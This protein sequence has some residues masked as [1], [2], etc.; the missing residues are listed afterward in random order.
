MNY[1]AK[2]SD[3]SLTRASNVLLRNLRLNRKT[4]N[5]LKRAGWIKRNETGDQTDAREGRVN[6]AQRNGKRNGTGENAGRKR[7][8]QQTGRKRGTSDARGNRKRDGRNGN[9]G[10]RAH[11]ATEKQTVRTEA[12]NG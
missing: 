11:D 10:Q 3:K 2:V 1:S 5:P 6:G 4:G 7:A 8:T 9:V 12:L